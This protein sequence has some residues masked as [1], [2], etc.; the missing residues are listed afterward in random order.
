MNVNH[1]AF[2]GLR[3]EYGNNL[4]KC[5]TLLGNEL[6][7]IQNLYQIDVKSSYISREK[8]RY[9]RVVAKY[10]SRSIDKAWNPAI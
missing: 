10:S 7:T 8:I 9:Y 3:L 2:P 4:Q 6:K 1:Q 5:N